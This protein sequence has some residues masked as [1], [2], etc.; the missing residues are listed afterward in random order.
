MILKSKIAFNKPDIVL[1][2][3]TKSNLQCMDSIQQSCFRNHYNHLDF[4]ASGTASGL[5]TFCKDS[6]LHLCES[7][8]SKHAVTTVLQITRTKDKINIKNVYA[9]HSTSKWVA[10]L[11]SLK[12]H[13]SSF[14]HPLSFFAGD[15]NMILN[16]G[17]K[18]GGLRKLDNDSTAFQ[19]MIDD[20]GLI[21]TP[22]KN[23][24]FTWNNRRG[25]DR[26]I[27]SRHD[28]FLLSEDLFLCSLEMEESIAP[29][30]GLDR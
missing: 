23:G 21:D 22:T 10:W 24:S 8:A 13:L 3:E 14:N 6:R 9:P 20:L 26:Q 11:H 17:E 30:V 15:F 27:A 2:Q 5:A 1:L 12:K 25:G 7:L 28:I 18:W 4:S 16:L 29:Q 19:S